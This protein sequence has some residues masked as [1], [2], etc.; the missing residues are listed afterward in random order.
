MISLPDGT[1]RLT[2][3]EA[4]TAGVCLRSR[5]RLDGQ[6]L[7]TKPI[8]MKLIETRGILRVFDWARHSPGARALKGNSG[9][10]LAVASLFI[11]YARPGHA[12]LS[13][14]GA[15]GQIRQIMKRFQP[16]I[17]YG[18]PSLESFDGKRKKSSFDEGSCAAGECE[19]R[20]Q[21]E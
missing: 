17:T 18:D 13:E 4:G 6:V 8:W 19:E 21:F 2:H 7:W 5:E 14:C 16:I 11:I 12:L 10:W 3:L 20:D 15:G 1:L 9:S